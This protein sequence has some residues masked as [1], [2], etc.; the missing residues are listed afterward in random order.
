MADQGRRLCIPYVLK[1][2]QIFVSEFSERYATPPPLFGVTFDERLLRVVVSYEHK[3]P[4]VRLGLRQDAIGGAAALRAPPS[5][6]VN[7]DP[8]AT[9]RADHRLAVSVPLR[10]LMRAAWREAG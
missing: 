2:V 9:Q 5:A 6:C 1:P 10:V 7:I 3:H 8:G 4:L